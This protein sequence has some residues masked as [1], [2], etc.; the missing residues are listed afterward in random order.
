MKAHT[1]VFLVVMVILV[2]CYIGAGYVDSF[3]T[4]STVAMG[5]FI[6]LCVILFWSLNKRPKNPT[7]GGAV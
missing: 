2:S 1:A 5:V 7:K 4:L 6:L 3:S